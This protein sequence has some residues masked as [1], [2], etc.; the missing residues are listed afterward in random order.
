[1]SGP[2]ARPQYMTEDFKHSYETTAADFERNTKSL[3]KLIESMTDDEKSKWLD[4]AKQCVEGAVIQLQSGRPMK[5]AEVYAL[6]GAMHIPP[7][8]E[9]MRVDFFRF[10]PLHHVLL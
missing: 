4:R 1:M 5:A 6:D 3:L 8:E 7:L 9:R 2:Q 10:H